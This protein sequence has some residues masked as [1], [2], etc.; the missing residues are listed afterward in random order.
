[1]LQVITT[2]VDRSIYAT[3]PPADTQ[4]TDTYNVYARLKYLNGEE[5]TEKKLVRLEQTPAD[6]R[7]D[8]LSEAVVQVLQPPL[9]VRRGRSLADGLAE[10]RAEPG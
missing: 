9:Q 4:R 2:V 1:M 7:V 8:G 3:H 5:E 6:V 10:Q